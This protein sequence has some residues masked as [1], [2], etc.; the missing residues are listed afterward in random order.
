M[1]FRS[2]KLFI[3][4]NNLY[5]NISNYILCDAVN[6]LHQG[7]LYFQNVI[8]FSHTCVYV[9]SLTPKWKNGPTRAKVHE[10]QRCS[11]VLYAQ[12]LHR[13]SPRSDNDCGK[14]GNILFHDPMRSMA[15]TTPIFTKLTDAQRYYMHN[16]YTE[17][18]P[19]LM[20]AGSME[21]YHFT[22]LC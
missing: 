11:T 6:T 3:V 15:F 19:D 2:Y 12:L 20:T 4:V 17:F 22:T 14:Y 16:S 9:I 8:R 1:P 5:N 10:T 7:I 13:I 21:I 18:H